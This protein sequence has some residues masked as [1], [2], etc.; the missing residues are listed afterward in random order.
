LYEGCC[1]SEVPGR[2]LLITGGGR[3]VARIDTLREF[4]VTEEPP[5]LT[6]RKYHFAVYHAQHV[7]VLGGYGPL[8]DCERYVCAERRWET[9][10]PL[11][12]ACSCMS[13]VV[14]EESLYC[15]GGTLDGSAI[16]DLIQ[17]LSLEG[18]TWELLALRLPEE[19]SGIP[20]FKLRT[21]VYFILGATLYSFKANPL[22]IQTVMAH[23]GYI[24]SWRG[25][26]HYS[27]GILYCS[28]HLGKVTR[29][30][31]GSLAS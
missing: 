12:Q 22:Q 25:P 20:C 29:V 7:Y 3:H 15:L 8:A 23:T 1:W 16:L 30:E 10:P 2:G 17:K 24:N 6:A 4:A 18:L 27:K 13:G 21:Q 14:M 9:L 5:M 31:I 26:S 11:P 19:S 28:F